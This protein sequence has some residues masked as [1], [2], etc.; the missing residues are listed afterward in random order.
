MPWLLTSNQNPSTRH[1]T[2]QT[3]PASLTNL[4]TV[5]AAMQS[6]SNHNDVTSSPS[7]NDSHAPPEENPSSSSAND[8]RS[9]TLTASALQAM[10][11]LSQGR[12]DPRYAHQDHVEENDDAR[13]TITVDTN[14]PDDFVAPLAMEHQTKVGGKFLGCCDY[15]RA[16]L[17]FSVVTIVT[18]LM[19]TVFLVVNVTSYNDDFQ[20]NVFLPGFDDDA[21]VDDMYDINTDLGKSLAIL[22]GVEVIFGFVSLFGALHF[23]SLHVS[24]FLDVS[25]RLV[26]AC[27]GRNELARMW[28]LPHVVLSNYDA[29]SAPPHSW[30]WDCLPCWR[31]QRQ[32][33]YCPFS[34]M[35]ISMICWKQ[36][37]KPPI[38]NPSFRLYY[39]LSF[40][41]CGC[42]LRPF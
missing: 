16:V 36:T 35:K 8:A 38:D 2:V 34:P 22:N 42:I 18:S 28:L 21:L 26:H 15:R 41:W 12:R 7:G 17:I 27:N 20:E 4:V 11:G 32:V 25:R 10:T 33:F 40:E 24:F 6:R 14:A 13:T 29:H 3:S 5:F 23:K 1:P 37:I 31:R 30:P 9:S 19:D 39:K